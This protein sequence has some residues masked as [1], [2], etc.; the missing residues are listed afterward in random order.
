MES[1]EPPSWGPPV[2]YIYT[3]KLDD[4][5]LAWEYLR[6][7]SSYRSDFVCAT[8]YQK[9]NILPNCWGLLQWE[10]PHE[11][12]RSVD[13]QW[14]CGANSETLL[15]AGR[16]GA[17]T[18][19]FDLWKIPGA[20]TLCHCG[21]YLN[22]TTRRGSEVL[23]RV[24]WPENLAQGVPLGIS[25]SAGRGLTVRTRAAQG[26]LR[27]LRGDAREPFPERPSVNAVTH[28]QILQALD[29]EAA[30]ASH[31]Q[32]ARRLFCL[33]ENFGW[34]ADSRW[35]ARVR[36]LLKCGRARS[37]TGYRRMV[38]LRGAEGESGVVSAP[39]SPRAV[40]LTKPRMRFAPTQRRTVAMSTAGAP[41]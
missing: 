1:I 6:R 5:S 19:S 16:A 14:L 33:S 31:R 18:P 23:R 12:A 10:D 34:D 30:G 20:K 37:A 4:C 36:Y 40:T 24:R 28:M 11:D 26:F 2:A 22:L 39:L 35:R 38:G 21:E 8:R 32:I 25:V 41:A 17:Y 13:P 7:N 9:R 15:V 27:S 3:L 29:G